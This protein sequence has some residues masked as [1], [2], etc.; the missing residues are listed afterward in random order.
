MLGLILSTVANSYAAV[1]IAAHSRAGGLIGAS[2]NTSIVNSYAMGSVAMLAGTDFI[3]PK[4][5]FC[6]FYDQYDAC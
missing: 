5:W 6:R 2:A 3:D 1:A 4:R